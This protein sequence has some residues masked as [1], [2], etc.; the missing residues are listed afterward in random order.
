[1]SDKPYS[2]SKNETTNDYSEDFSA[3]RLNTEAA[4]HERSVLISHMQ[5]LFD[6]LVETGQAF[7]ASDMTKFMAP[8][9]NVPIVIVNREPMFVKASPEAQRFRN[10]LASRSKRCSELDRKVRGEPNYEEFGASWRRR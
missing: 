2:S 6:H 7:D 8:G 4:H 5:M 3:T 1:M 10:W 9:K